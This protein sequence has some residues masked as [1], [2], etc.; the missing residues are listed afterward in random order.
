MVAAVFYV[1][2]AASAAYIFLGGSG[3]FLNATTQTV[4]KLH[5]D[6]PC[7]VEKIMVTTGPKL[8][9]CGTKF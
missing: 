6:I 3:G 9:T 7:S 4:S 2:E 8:K 5:A 1:V